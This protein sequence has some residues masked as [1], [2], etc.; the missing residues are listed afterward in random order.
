M[1]SAIA[2]TNPSDETVAFA[3]DELHVT[4]AP[5]ITLPAASFTVATRVAVSPIDVKLT[6]VGDRVTEAAV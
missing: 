4:V 2:V 1:P 3:L 5:D 6:L